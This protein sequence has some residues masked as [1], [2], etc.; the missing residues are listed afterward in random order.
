MKITKDFG[1]PWGIV[2]IPEG[3]TAEEI[4]AACSSEDHFSH[5]Y[6][7][8]GWEKRV[9][10]KGGI[11]L[12]GPFLLPDGWKALVAFPLGGEK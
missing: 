1:Y 7:D 2:E 8:P 5:P 3:Y 12:D 9:G 10:E 4:P 6:C 11:V